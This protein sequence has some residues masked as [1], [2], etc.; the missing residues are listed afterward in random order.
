MAGQ[1]SRWAHLDR[2]A[3]EVEE[4]ERAWRLAAVF[5]KGAQIAADQAD[6]AAYPGAPASAVDAVNRALA[7]AKAAAYAADAAARAATV[8][9]VGGID[10]DIVQAHRRATKGFWG[11]VV[12]WMNV[13]KTN[14]R[15]A[16]EELIEVVRVLSEVEDDK[17][18]AEAVGSV[19]GSVLAAEEE[20]EY[21]VSQM[22]GV[23]WDRGEESRTL[24]VGRPPAEGLLEKAPVEGVAVQEQR[25]AAADIEMAGP[26]PSDMEPLTGI[27]VD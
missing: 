25:E 18:E 27:S 19:L 17:Q 8:L 5:A 23:E 6:A 9:R 21:V 2:S 26:E 11:G 22:E 14:Y 4:D 13:G 10:H 12:G 3:A 16:C 7:C 24:K 1:T 15:R 20:G